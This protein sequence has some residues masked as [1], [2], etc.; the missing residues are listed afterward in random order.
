MVKN[1]LKRQYKKSIRK[2]QKNWK[3]VSIVSQTIVFLEEDNKES[4]KKKGSKK[5][6]PKDKAK[7]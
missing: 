2:P 5:P 7:N 6:G 3:N 1:R 4:P